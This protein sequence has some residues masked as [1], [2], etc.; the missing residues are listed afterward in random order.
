M[1]FTISNMAPHQCIACDLV[2][3]KITLRVSVSCLRLGRYMT[4]DFPLWSKILFGINAA[5]YITPNV[6]LG[7]DT[8]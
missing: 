3:T 2:E 6:E 5:N 8:F 4:S 7:N 1:D